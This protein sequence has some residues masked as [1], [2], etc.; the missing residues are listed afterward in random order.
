MFRISIPSLPLP[1]SAS[2][3]QGIAG[4]SL[5]LTTDAI[6]V[7]INPTARVAAGPVVILENVPQPSPSPPPLGWSD[8]KS[9]TVMIGPI[10]YETNRA[11]LR[12]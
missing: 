9:A 1:C 2:G 12:S 10:K 5:K 4:G 7:K 3:K 8:W 11:E 6:A